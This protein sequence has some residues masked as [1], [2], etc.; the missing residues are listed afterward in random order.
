LRR[1]PDIYMKYDSKYPE[2]LRIEEVA[3]W[4]TKL[5]MDLTFLYFSEP[6][7]LVERSVLIMLSF[8]TLLQ[9]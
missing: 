8:L 7:S 6:V 1:T 2:D 9:G 3:N 5:K 4:I